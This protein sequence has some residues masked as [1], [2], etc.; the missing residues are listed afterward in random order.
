M[1]CNQQCNKIKKVRSSIS[2]TDDDGLSIDESQIPSKFIDHYTTIAQKLAC[3]VPDTPTDYTSHL[4][5]KIEKTFALFPVIPNEIN[6]T[7][8]NLKDNGRTANSIATSVLIE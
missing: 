7:I 8:D 4:K 2:L 6:P 3:K 1:G 5:D